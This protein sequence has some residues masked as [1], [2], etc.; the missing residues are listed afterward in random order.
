MPQ[1]IQLWLLSR[2]RPNYLRETILSAL[3][4]DPGNYEL[5]IVISDNYETDIVSIMM[6]NEF[7]RVLVKREIPKF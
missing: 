4:Q 6:K 1:N 2:V 7:P 5:E 3:N